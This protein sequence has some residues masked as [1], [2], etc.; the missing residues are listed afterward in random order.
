MDRAP[1]AIGY[2]AALP[3][4]G[5]MGSVRLCDNTMGAKGAMKQ[6]IQIAVVGS[7]YVGL[8]A[9]MCFAEMG[10]RVIC[11]DNDESKVA[12]LKSGDSLIHE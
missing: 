12:A 7:G 1:V 5:G 11:V 9:A 3:I 10:H 2:A 6:P 8:V 4:L